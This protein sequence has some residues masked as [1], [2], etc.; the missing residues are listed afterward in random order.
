MANTDYTFKLGQ[1]P[2]RLFR[3]NYEKGYTSPTD[4]P[5]YIYQVWD[6]DRGWTDFCRANEAEH[7]RYYARHLPA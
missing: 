3:V 5:Q 2:D 4:G 1:F 6:E 7:E